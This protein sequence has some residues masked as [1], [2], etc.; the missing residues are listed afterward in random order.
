METEVIADTFTK[1]A[2]KREFIIFKDWVDEDEEEAMVMFMSDWG[3]DILKH[4]S[5]WLFDGTY[6]A[7][8]VPSTQIYICLAAPEGQGQGIPVGWFLLPNKKAKTYNI[9]FKA[10]LQK[11]GGQPDCLKVVVS[12]FEAAIFKIVRALFKNVEHK[13]CKFHKN[14]AIWKKLGEYGLQSLYHRNPRFT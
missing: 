11:L 12:D 8:P 3:A 1:T 10:L 4:H 13:G 5:T 6:S 7:C 9:M 14:A 2:D